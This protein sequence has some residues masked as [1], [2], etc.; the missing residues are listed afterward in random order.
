MDRRLV[1]VQ[2]L[3]EGPDAALELEDIV[4][5]VPLVGELDPY[6][7]VQKGQLP[8]PLRQHVVVELDV[9]ED[10]RA[11]PEANRRA[12]S[13]GLADHGRGALRVRRGVRCS[14][15][16]AVA[17]DRQLQHF[18]QRVDDRHA[19]AVQAAG[20]LVG[21][22]VEL[23]ARVE[24]GHDDFGGGPT[25]LRVDIDGDAAAIV[26]DRDGFVRVDG[27]RDFV[28]IAGQRLVDGVVDD[29]EHHVVQAGAVIG[30][31]DVHAGPLADRFE[32]L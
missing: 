29:L 28:A 25:L 6:A 17:V 16:L 5:I 24:H 3:D 9:R 32:A 2:V 4:A 13:L 21:V 12:A 23:T 26:G 19:D 1:A 27:D 31:A 15:M 14:W 8:Q 11:R 22:V 7:R 18:G 30:V 10:R 20:D